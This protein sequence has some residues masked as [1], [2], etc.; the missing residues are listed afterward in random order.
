M[1]KITVDT[2]EPATGTSLTLG[3]NGDTITIPA[4]ATITNSG[5]ST[6]FGG[7]VQLVTSKSQAKV[8]STTVL[9]WE[10]TSAWTTSMGAELLTCSITPTSSS[11][12]LVVTCNIITTTESGSV[13]AIG[14]WQDSGTNAIAGANGARWD[15]DTGTPIAIIW[16]QAAGTTSST[17]FKVRG[18]PQS[19]GTLYMNG[20]NNTVAWGG[21][22]VSTITIM[23]IA[24]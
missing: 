13:P 5:T 3:A 15:T 20:R 9:D 12:R 6:G 1:S 8:T 17:T 23:E 21:V 11:N 7:L 18:G 10:S 22:P 4:G 2:V 14:L 24:V 16:E 19:S